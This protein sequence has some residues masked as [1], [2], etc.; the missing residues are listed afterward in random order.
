MFKVE[1]K[2]LIFKTKLIL[3]FVAQATK[4]KIAE[5]LE[6]NALSVDMKLILKQLHY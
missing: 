1:D 3:N 6:I 5:G 4:F 2:G